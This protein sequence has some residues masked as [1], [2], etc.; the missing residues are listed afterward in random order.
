MPHIQQLQE[1]PLAIIGDIHGELDALD[2]LLTC[3]DNHHPDHHIV[4]LGDLADRGPDSPG[5]ICR[6]RERMALGAQ[7][8]L[9]N[10]ELS[11]LRGKDKGYNRWFFTEGGDWC[12][13]ETGGRVV[14][15]S[16]LASSSR[17]DVEELFAGLPLALEREGLRVVHACWD[18]QAIAR[19]RNSSESVLEIFNSARR[20]PLK[21]PEANWGED[22]P[23]PRDEAWEAQE[24]GQQ[25]DNAVAVLT[26]GKERRAGGRRG[27]AERRR[28][29]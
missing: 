26:S 2:A 15:M 6:V 12:H 24:V 16:P 20:N 19:V 7:C 3:L 17:E 27:R 29:A 13:A 22:G 8:V 1:G 25:N 28:F 10:H 21:E 9:G 18:D 23:P 11:V 4:F 14:P 5:V